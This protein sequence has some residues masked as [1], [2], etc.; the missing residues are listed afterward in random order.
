MMTTVITTKGQVVIPSKVRKHMNIKGGTKLTVIESGSRII[1][2]PLTEEYFDKIAG[3]LKGKESLS[4]QLIRERAKEREQG[5]KK[6][7]K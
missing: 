4:A 6:W 5:D 2:Q 1:L 3:I 7:N